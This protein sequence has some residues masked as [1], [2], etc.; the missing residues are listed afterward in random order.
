[1]TC[2][3]SGEDPHRIF[4]RTWSPILKSQLHP[5][6]PQ[7]GGGAACAHFTNGDPE[8]WSTAAGSLGTMLAPSRLPSVLSCP[9]VQM[10]HSVQV[11]EVGR[12]PGCAPAFPPSALPRPLPE[13]FSRP[14]GDPLGPHTLSPPEHK[15]APRRVPHANPTPRQVQTGGMKREGPPAPEPEPQRLQT[16]QAPHACEGPVSSSR[17][18]HEPFYRQRNGGSCDVLCV[19]A[20]GE[21]LVELGSDPG[22][23]EPRT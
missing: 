9:G 21:G 20:Q 5:N 17:G 7:V 10:A 15:F 2:P 16:G 1:M 4:R 18:P 12:G 3:G 13:H 23:S 14:A 22:L 19:R 11:P 6:R 8:V